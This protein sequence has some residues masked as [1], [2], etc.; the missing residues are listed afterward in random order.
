MHSSDDHK[1]KTGSDVKDLNAFL[2]VQKIRASRKAMRM[3]W[4]AHSGAHAE[5]LWLCWCLLLTSMLGIS[6]G[7]ESLCLERR[8]QLHPKQLDPRH[9]I[10]SGNLCGMI[11]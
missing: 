8:F 7:R 9:V 3:S 11:N 6:R 4:L 10:T 2:T 1:F 5:S